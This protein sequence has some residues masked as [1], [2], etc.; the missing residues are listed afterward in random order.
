MIIPSQQKP[1][2][3]SIR[4]ITNVLLY[5]VP[6]YLGYTGDGKNYIFEVHIQSRVFIYLGNYSRCKN[7]NFTNNLKVC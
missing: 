4:K 5:N 3:Q 2:C 6:N 7:L 1:V